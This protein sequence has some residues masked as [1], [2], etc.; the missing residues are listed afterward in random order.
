MNRIDR[1]TAIVTQLQSKRL[2][3]AEEI[4]RRF[5]VSL[6]TVYRDMRALDEAGI[7]IIGEAGH[8]Y[9]L[10]EGYRLPPVMFTQE[11][12]R[13]FLVAEKIF[14]KVTDKG[15]SDHFRSAM[16]KIK[17]VLR[18]AEKDRLEELSPLVEVIRMRNQLQAGKKSEFL[19]SILNSL[20]N[21]NLIEIIYTTFEEEKTAKRIIEPVGVYYSF[22][23][24]YLIAWC[25]LRNDYRNFRIDRIQELQILDKNY[26]TDSHPKLKDF[27]DQVR[28]TE[29]LTQIEIFVPTSSEKYI[30]EQKYNHGFVTEKWTESGI[31]MTFVT[32]SME[33]F[34]RWMLMM[35]DKIK[36]ISPPE[37]KARMRE[38]IEEIMGNL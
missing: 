18:T 29:N 13:A 7:P 11:E 8:G 22:E 3:K 19:Q 5:S 20:S 14:E 4:A 17:A 32:S 25:R 35:A 2:T 31:E 6:R 26:R 12:A 37:A 16:L 10:V 24:W 28:H 30:R 33:G 38:L 34:I 23:Q 21:K 15:S 27:L 9:S 1:L 36:I